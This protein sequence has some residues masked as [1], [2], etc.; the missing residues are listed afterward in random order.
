MGDIRDEANEV[1]RDYVTDG[2]PASGVNEP[3]KSGIRALFALIEDAVSAAGENGAY[4]LRETKALLD[5]DLA[6]DAG[7]YAL[8]Q[9]D[10]TEANNGYYKKSGASGAGSWAF[11]GADP[12]VGAAAVAEAAAAEAEGFKDEAEAARDVAIAAAGPS[13]VLPAMVSHFYP[14][15]E[16]AGTAM[17][18]VIGTAHIDLTSGSTSGISWVKGGWLQI[19]SGWFKLP[20]MAHRCIIPV[21]R[22]PVGMSTGYYLCNKD[23]VAIGAAAGGGPTDVPTHKILSGWGIHPVTRR[24]DAGGSG[25]YELNSGGWIMAAPV[26]ASTVTGTPVIGAA[27]TSGAG[28]VGS[29]ELAGL[30]ILDDEPTDADL[31]R[32]LDYERARQAR[33]GIYLTHED[34]PEKRILLVSHGESTDEGTFY[35]T[36]TGS[37]SGTTLTVTSVSGGVTLLPGHVFYNGA[38]AGVGVEEQLTG[39]PGG[40][41]TYRLSASATTGSTAWLFSG[42]SIAAQNDFSQTTFIK[43]YNSDNATTFGRMER[44]SAFPGYQNNV[45]PSRLAEGPKSGWELGF[46]LARNER[47]DDGRMVDILRPAKGSTFLLPGGDNN[48]SSSTDYTDATGATK[49]I[50]AGSSRNPSIIAGGGLFSTLHSRN[51]CRAEQDARNRGIAYNTVIFQK[52][53]GQNDASVGAA[54]ITSSAFYQGLHE[55]ERDWLIADTGIANL[56]QIIIKAKEPAAGDPLY[57]ADSVGTSRLTALD[58]VRTGIDDFAADHAGLVTVLDGSDYSLNIAGGND[59][60]HPDAAGYE[61]MGRDIE[62]AARA[63]YS[64]TVEPLA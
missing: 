60:D 33:R 49:T 53:E 41:G 51:R 23:G 7:T 3:Q 25:A 36:A 16:G 42:L 30:Y 5:A 17:R 52:N 57:P 43:A 48:T 56:L 40:A 62:T 21:L 32:I 8:V 11:L 29:M 19:T 47:P 55:D 9:F 27:N 59:Y 14:V 64:V 38:L 44:L 15:D 34:G 28:A 22:V 61:L 37:V 10:S 58:R 39:T 4:I 63:F 24:P 46:K 1:Y 12:R 18:D 2:V 50:S 54:A 31:R 35:A 13:A 26:F 45:P 20:S 6:H